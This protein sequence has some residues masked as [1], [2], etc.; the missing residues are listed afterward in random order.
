MAGK[1]I[2]V[3]RITGKRFFWIVKC[4]DCYNNPTCSCLLEK[5]PT[6]ERC[7]EC[8]PKLC[9]SLK[10]Q[11]KIFRLKFRNTESEYKKCTVCSS[12]PLEID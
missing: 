11:C 9:L 1:I 8:T 4:L 3:K 12:F 10:I 7:C 2:A 5:C 6:L